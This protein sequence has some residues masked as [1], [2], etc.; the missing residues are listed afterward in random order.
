LAVFQ[1]VDDILIALLILL[2]VSR[3]LGLMSKRFNLSPMVGEVLGG[4]LLSPLFLNVLAVGSDLELFASFAIIVIMFHSGISTDF[5]SFRRHQVS[6]LVIAIMGVAVTAVSI[7]CLV[8][9]VLGFPFDTSLFLGAIIANSAI[10]VTASI[11]RNS[12]ERLRAIVIGASFVDDVMAVFLLGVVLTFVGSEP[13][14]VLP[15]LQYMG[16]HVSRGVALLITSAKVLFFLLSVFFIFSKLFAV[17]LD[18]FVNRGFE[19]LLTIG[20][21]TAF[22]LGIFSKWVG[23]HEVIGV[24]LAGLILA[25]WGILPDP[26]LTRGIASMKF[27]ETLSFMMDS[28]FSPIFFGFVGVLLGGALAGLGGDLAMIYLWVVLIAA[29]AIGGKII[30][31]GLGAKL[32][33][34]PTPGALLIGIALGGRGALEFILIQSGLNTGLLDQSQFSTI[35]LVVLV[36]ILITPFLFR[37]VRT[38]SRDECV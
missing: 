5:S 10:E 2:L 14:E 21:L 12:S 23:L 6:S 9:L 30:G 15:L 11:L 19:V 7:F 34:F 20:F 28:L 29:I 16:V 8:Y 24:Y 22:G 37:L 33:G 32:R 3:V 36:T 38:R 27:Q 26:M 18:R 1:P 31:C 25:R 13:H 4:L 35:I 17:L